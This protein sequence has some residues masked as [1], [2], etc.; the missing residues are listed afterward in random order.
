MPTR[1]RIQWANGALSC[2]TYPTMLE[3]TLD[4]FL[5]IK[6]SFHG[7]VCPPLFDITPTRERIGN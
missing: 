5:Q 4:A 6:Y 3:A 7:A 2:E 1:Y